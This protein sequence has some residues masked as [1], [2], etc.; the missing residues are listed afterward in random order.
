MKDGSDG[1]VSRQ[2]FHH[3][4]CLLWSLL[5]APVTVCCILGRGRARKQSKKEEVEI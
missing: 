1:G 3:I 2:L 4:N 5:T